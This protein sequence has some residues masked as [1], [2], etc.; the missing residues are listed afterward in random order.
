M[1]SLL[2]EFE[3][4]LSSLNL[5]EYR[6]TYTKYKTVEL[7]LSKRILPL[8]HIYQEYWHKYSDWKDYNKFYSFY[9]SD[10]KQEIEDFRDK[11]FFSKETFRIGFKARI[12]R[13]WVSLLTQV[14]GAYVCAELFGFENVKMNP[15]NDMLGKDIVIKKGLDEKIIQIKKQ[16]NRQD[17]KRGKIGQYPE[18]VY[19][20][21]PKNKLLKNGE[22]SKSF[23]DWES[24][25][26]NKLKLLPNNFIV[27]KRAMFE[28]IFF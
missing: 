6:E 18:V 26:S 1:K 2:K 9:Y 23:K 20:V 22:K 12:Y 13:T 27:F 17:F 19:Q 3:I 7:N 5:T 4:F 14:Q 16:S 25:Y 15:K 24:K 21:P 10:L 8:R 28:N 11:H